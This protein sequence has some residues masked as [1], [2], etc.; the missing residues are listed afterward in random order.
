MKFVLCHRIILEFSKQKNKI[1][2]L[3]DIYYKYQIAY[4]IKLNYII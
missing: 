2:M 3:F 4:L 1:H